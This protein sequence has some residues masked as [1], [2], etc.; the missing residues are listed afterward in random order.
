MKQTVDNSRSTH[1]LKCRFE[2]LKALYCLNIL[3]KEYAES[4]SNSYNSGLKR[5]A[6]IHSQRKKALYSLKRYIL[7]KFIE[8]DCVKDIRTHE[9]GGRTYYCVYVGEFSY[10]TPVSEWETPP[11]D[12]PESAV[13]LESFDADPN[14]RTRDINEREALKLLSD[15]FES[16]NYYIESP[17]TDDGYGGSFIGW[18]YL[19]GSLEEGDKVPDRHLYDH[20]GENDFIFNVRDT[21][22][23]SEGEC[24]IVDRYHAYLTPIYDRSPLLQR[25]AYDVL[26]DGEKKE[27]IRDKRITDEW[28][29]LADTID[30]PIP[31]VEGRLSDSARKAIRDYDTSVDFEIGDII[32]VKTASEDEPI[33]CRLTEVHVSGPF[34]FGQY[35]PVEPTEEAPLGLSIHEIAD[36]IVAVHDEPPAKEDE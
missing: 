16:P 5:K 34:L 13:E 8:N 32:E 20:N 23:T 1:C 11:E 21:F 14:S 4:A 31:N 3:A 2:N 12:A 10:H 35:E 6:R 36:D 29:V 30:D 15:E 22:Q 27:C 9:I 33:Y 24:E 7:G 28:F 19:P 17:F 18:S 25:P 26:L